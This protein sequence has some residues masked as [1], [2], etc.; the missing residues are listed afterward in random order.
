MWGSFFMGLCCNGSLYC[1]GPGK[2]FPGSTGSLLL[3]A[4]A[5]GYT[6]SPDHSS[7]SS[8]AGTLQACKPEP[9]DCEWW[10]FVLWDV[11]CAVPG[12]EG[13]SGLIPFAGHGVAWGP[14]FPVS[15]F[16]PAQLSTHEDIVKLRLWALCV[17]VCFFVALCVSSWLWQHVSPT[18]NC[19]RKPWLVLGSLGWSQ[20]CSSHGG[21]LT[22]PPLHVLHV[23]AD[24]E[25]LL[26]ALS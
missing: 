21:R 23:L 12:G 17:L 14:G 15:T 7:D 11:R 18:H 20:S 16:P 6:H 13:D 10:L 5:P 2:A 3:S 24:L 8:T 9:F 22:P 25:T 19:G 4:W 1:E 26:G